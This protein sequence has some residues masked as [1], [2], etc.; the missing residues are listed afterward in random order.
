MRCGFL[1]LEKVKIKER[2]PGRAMVLGTLL[3]VAG[4]RSTD[5]HDSF[6]RCHFRLK[7]SQIPHHLTI[8]GS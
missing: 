1:G 8:N 5:A 4:A 6:Q 2:I 3:I 7:Y